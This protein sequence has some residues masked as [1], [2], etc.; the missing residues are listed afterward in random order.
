VDRTLQWTRL[1]HIVLWTVKYNMSSSPNLIVP[2]EARPLKI[3]QEAIYTSSLISN[4]L[5]LIT[6]IKLTH[7]HIDLYLR[8]KIKTFQYDD[9]QNVCTYFS[10]LTKISA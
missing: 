5:R 4:A 7:L 6:L 1:N 8:K 3:G 10:V 2:G 9:D